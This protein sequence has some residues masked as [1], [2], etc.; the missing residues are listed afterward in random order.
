VFN[1]DVTAHPI[2]DAA[3]MIASVKACATQ[4][5]N[6]TLGQW[7]APAAALAAAKRVA[8]EGWILGVV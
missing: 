8:E 5:A 7:L 6:G 1:P 2:A 4:D 3:Q